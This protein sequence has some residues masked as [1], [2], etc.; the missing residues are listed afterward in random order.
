MPPEGK[1]EML[2]SCAKASRHGQIELLVPVVGGGYSAVGSVGQD[3]RV[4][5][6]DLA[7]GAILATL[8]QGPGAM[9]VPMDPAPL[10]AAKRAMLAEVCATEE[11]RPAMR[12]SASAPTMPR[13]VMPPSPKPTV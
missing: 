3:M 10:L 4:R 5:I 6:L 1:Y 7:T 8:E 2:W 9:Q 12:K 11:E 13:V